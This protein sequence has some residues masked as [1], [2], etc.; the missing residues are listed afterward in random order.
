MFGAPRQLFLTL[1]KTVF[2][3][4][5]IRVEFDHVF[6]DANRLFAVKAQEL[7][8]R[9]I[10]DVGANRGQ[11]GLAIRSHGYGGRLISFE[12]LSEAHAVMRQVS[13]A[14]SLWE[15]AP[16]M[17]LGREA[18]TTT[19][20]ISKNLASSSLL[21]VTERSTRA[22]EASSFNG[23]EEIQICRMDDVVSATTEAPLGIKLDT[24]GFELE[25]LRGAE[26][27]LSKAAVVLVELSLAP[28]YQGGAAFAEVFSLLEGKGFRCIALCEG[29]SDPANNEVLQVDGVFV[30]PLD[31]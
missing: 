14:D 25:V 4:F 6:R 27:T 18:S 3:Q 9:T 26:S 17:A 10:L 23:T 20:N 8:V 13:H 16:Q 1:V 5:G 30:R 12:P 22:S 29:F 21:Q 31:V 2:R 7:G 15:I 19:I 28:L 24:Q 11:F